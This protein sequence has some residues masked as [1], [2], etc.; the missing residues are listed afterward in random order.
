MALTKCGDAVL[1]EVVLVVVEKKVWLEVVDRMYQRAAVA[2]AKGRL[3]RGGFFE[4]KE[5]LDKRFIK[6]S[7]PRI[8]IRQ[9]REV[10]ICCMQR[11]WGYWI[12]KI[13]KRTTKTE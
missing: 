2:A 9:Y 13:C 1:L 5:R 6:V 3:A 11:K 7:L 8:Q 10:N 4:N 12:E